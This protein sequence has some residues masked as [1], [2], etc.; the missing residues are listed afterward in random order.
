MSKEHLPKHDMGYSEEK[1][2]KSI[3]RKKLKNQA[4]ILFADSNKKKKT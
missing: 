4:Q 1:L 3:D 2:D